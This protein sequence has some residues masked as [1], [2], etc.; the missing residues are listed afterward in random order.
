[1]SSVAIRARQAISL[2]YPSRSLDYP[3]RFALRG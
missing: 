3:S 1:V 2:D